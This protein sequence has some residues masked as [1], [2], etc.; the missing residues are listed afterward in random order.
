MPDR[1]W[2]ALR[3]G[4]ASRPADRRRAL[5]LAR[6][7]PRAVRAPARLAASGG[8]SS[9]WRH[10]P[11]RCR[12]ASGA[13]RAGSP[14]WLI[15]SPPAGLPLRARFPGL[16]RPGRWSSR[17]ALTVLG[18]LYVPTAVARRRVRGAVDLV[19]ELLGG[20][21]D[22][23]TRFVER[24][25]G[26][27]SATR[28]VPARSVLSVL[29]RCSCLWRSARWTSGS[30]GH[31][32]RAPFADAGPGSGDSCGVHARR[33][34]P[35]SCS[36]WWTGSDVVAW[37]PGA[38]CADAP[39]PGLALAFLVGLAALA[40]LH[41]AGRCASP[42]PRTGCASRRTRTARHAAIA[43]AVE[44]SVSWASLRPPG[45]AAALGDGFRCADWPAL[46]PP[47]PAA[48]G[49]VTSRQRRRRPV[50]AI[51]H[52]ATLRAAPRAASGP[53]SVS[54]LALRRERRLDQAAST[55]RAAS[56]RRSRARIARARPSGERRRIERDLHDGAQQRLVALRTYLA[57][58]S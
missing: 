23:P 14:R 30:H 39:A 44:G 26:A 24:E 58:E 10:R 15:V 17:S 36:A 27:G 31:A 16:R 54:A 55:A 12:T 29:L 45:S 11:S 47:E 13:S 37:L 40:P 1:G 20:L 7:D 46:A 19:H 38:L 3:N 4:L 57:L 32:A 21:P 41:G 53:V 8:W 48:D 43:E 33:S 56:C 34:I 2:L 25:P 22:E 28:V 9:R 51:I 50:A 42:M 18:L 5:R 6:G 49:E 52:D 35:S